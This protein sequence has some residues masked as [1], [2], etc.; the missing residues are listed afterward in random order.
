MAQY[1]RV[2]LKLSGEALA[3]DKGFGF[4][5]TNIMVVAKQ[6]RHL[7]DQ[8]VEI[9]VVI[10]GGNFW[11]GR[12]D[13]AMDRTKAD[14][15]G[16]MATIMNA[17][18]ASVRFRTIGLET[19]VQTPF[20]VGMMT[21]RFTKDTAI[22]HLKKGRVVFFAGGLGHPYFSTDTAAALRAIEIEAEVILLA[23]NIDG[24]YDSDPNI[25]ENAEKYDTITFKEVISK[26]LQVMDQSA[27]MMCLE[28]KMPVSVFYLNDKDS[29]IHASEGKINGTFITVD[30]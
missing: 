29:I 28:Q 13:G 14:E 27:A 25:N 6:V 26:N 30:Q 10:G 5:K 8:G 3:G 22:R 1:K 7:V 21:E 16:M 19:V 11:R 9:G 23:K 4:D 24:V 12:S 17:L 20:E 18:Y 15:I 2:L